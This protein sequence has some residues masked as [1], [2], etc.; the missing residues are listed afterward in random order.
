MLLTVPVLAASLV[1]LG[2]R[3]PSLATGIAGSATSLA[4]AV[5]SGRLAAAA[6]DGLSLLVL[7]IP[8][9]GLT[10]TVVRAARRGS[11]PVGGRSVA[12][13]ILTFG[14]PR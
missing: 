14:A 9:V 4:A 12:K 6:L 8:I 3:L 10:A 13:A 11:D 5:G 1:Y 2:F 7:A